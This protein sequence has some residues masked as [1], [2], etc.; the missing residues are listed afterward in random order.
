MTSL[1]LLR[2][3]AVM[4]GLLCALAASAHAMLESTSPANQATVAR[5]P[6]ALELR[7]SHPSRL[8]SLRL[9]HEGRDTALTIDPFATATSH[10]S[11]ALPVLKAGTWQVH[12][13]ALSGDGHA[14]K[15]NWS[16]TISAP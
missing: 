9:R 8:T 16:F 1:S 7:F 2:T 12:W 10:V 4:A 5:A 14:M 13:G 3:V 11:V 6:A 15:G